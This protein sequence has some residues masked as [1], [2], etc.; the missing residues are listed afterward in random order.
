M[1][2]GAVVSTFLLATEG[3]MLQQPQVCEN[4]ARSSS[5]EYFAC[6]H[7]PLNI[8]AAHEITG[9]A[10][11]SVATKMTVHFNLFGGTHLTMTFLTTS[12]LCL[13]PNQHML[14]LI[15]NLPLAQTSVLTTGS[16][17]HGRDCAQAGNE[18][19]S[20]CAAWPHRQPGR[21]R[22]FCTHRAGLWCAA[23]L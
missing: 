8:F 20:R 16:I 19:A 13:V 14:G 3:Q 11:P 2:P 12:A 9:F 4:A 5:S 7:N 18:A 17:V 23:C 1:L 22:L 10:D 15:S 21:H 6:R